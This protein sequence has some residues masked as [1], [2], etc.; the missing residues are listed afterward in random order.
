MLEWQRFQRRYV[1]HLLASEE[2][3][4]KIRTFLRKFDSRFRER[5]CHYKD[6]QGH[7]R[8][9]TVGDAKRGKLLMSLGKNN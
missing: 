1:C 6:I 5:A 8:T 4:G 7:V 9:E 3:P 2:R